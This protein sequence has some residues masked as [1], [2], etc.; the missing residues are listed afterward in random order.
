MNPATNF[1]IK[2][3]TEM[4]NPT[5]SLKPIKTILTEQLSSNHDLIVI[6]S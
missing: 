1:E 6:K 4:I 5:K 2:I 3:E